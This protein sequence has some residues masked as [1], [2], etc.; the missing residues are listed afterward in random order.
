MSF[1]GN[2]V[3]QNDFLV[4]Y[5]F[6]LPRVRAVKRIGPH[7]WEFCQIAVGLLLSD[8]HAEKHGN[9][10]RLSFQRELLVQMLQRKFHLKCNIQS[11]GDRKQL[12][13]RVYVSVYSMPLLRSIVLQHLHPSMYYKLGVS[14]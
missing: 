3:A 12:Q 2:V 8:A 14:N 7:S 6:F 4:T 1:W 11:A 13:Y 10:V 5:A 9:G